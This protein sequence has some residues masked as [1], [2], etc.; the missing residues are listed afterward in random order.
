MKL[1]SDSH[2]CDRKKRSKTQ[3]QRKNKWLWSS[4]AHRNRWTREIHWHA[5]YGEAAHSKS[6][7]F[8]FHISFNFHFNADSWNLFDSCAWETGW[9]SASSVKC[10]ATHL[11]RTRLDCIR[12]LEKYIARMA[13]V[14]LILLRERH[15]QFQA[16]TC[17]STCAR[18]YLIIYWKCNSLLSAARNAIISA[19]HISSLHFSVLRCT[20]AAFFRIDARRTPIARPCLAYRTV[21]YCELVHRIVSIRSA[22]R[23]FFSAAATQINACGNCFENE[24]KRKHNCF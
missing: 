24:T 2:L 10:V 6:N 20:C 22:A 3:K 19:C 13:W 1:S 14:R 23:A 12:H 18:S 5:A 16:A 7:H 17:S 11:L 21:A 4:E 15:T 9:W 8:F